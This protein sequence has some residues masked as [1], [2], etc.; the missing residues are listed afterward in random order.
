MYPAGLPAHAYFDILLN[1]HVWMEHECIKSSAVVVLLSCCCRC[2][3]VVEL[4]KTSIASHH[5]PTSTG[6]SWVFRGMRRHRTWHMQILEQYGHHAHKIFGLHKHL[7]FD[8]KQRPPYDK[9]ATK[10]F[11]CTTSRTKAKSY[12][13]KSQIRKHSFEEDQGHTRWAS[14]WTRTTPTAAVSEATS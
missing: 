7:T 3:V 12:F 1:A 8:V 5:A 4:P 13:D 2:C 6:I 14:E 11:T 9:V 10:S